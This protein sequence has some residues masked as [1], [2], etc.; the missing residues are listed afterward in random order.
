MMKKLWNLIAGS[1]SRRYA[2]PRAEQESRKRV[3][4]R[5]FTSRFSA[6]ES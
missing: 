2:L 5:R 3:P 6:F 1:F 4:T